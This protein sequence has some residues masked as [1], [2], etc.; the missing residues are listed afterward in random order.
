M[1][2]LITVD[3]DYFIPE[4]IRWDMGHR[5][6]GFFLEAAWRFR[7]QV[8]DKMNLNGEQLYFWEKL[9]K[10]TGPLCLTSVSDSHCY[11]THDPRYESADAI[12]LFDQHHDCFKKPDTSYV[13]C[14]NWAWA[15]LDGDKKR[16]LYW[17]RPY[18]LD[19]KYHLGFTPPKGRT[20]VK[21]ITWKDLPKLVEGNKVRGVHVCRSGCWTPPWL[22]EEFIKFASSASHYERILNLQDEGLWNAMKQRWEDTEKMIE[23]IRFDWLNMKEKMLHLQ[24]QAV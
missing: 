14:G 12:I 19:E 1:Q 24:S 17:M 8:I 11:I 10:I 6:S 16:H 7:P 9:R 13:D 23:D 21:V 18:Y 4:D 15:W 3:W 20:R 22:D 5:E 2:I